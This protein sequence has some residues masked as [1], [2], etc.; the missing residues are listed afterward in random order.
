MRT[1]VAAAAIVLAAIASA[2]ESDIVTTKVIGKEFPGQYKHPASFAELDNGDLYLAYYG[3]GGEYEDDSKVWGM[4]LR[5]GTEQWSTPEIIAD[6]P[7]LGEG[8]P[9]VWQAPDATVWLFYVQRYGETWSESR[10]NAKI[11]RDGARIWS[12]SF[13][14]AFEKGMM[15]RGRPIL[16]QDGDYLLPIYHETGNDRE[17]VGADTTSLFIRIDPDTH[18]WKETGRITSRT[19]NLQPAPVEIE[20]GHLIAY[21]RRGGGYE[22]VTDGYVVR[23]ESR[24]GGWTWSPGVDSA[25]PNPNAAVDFIKLANGH[26]LL[27]YNDSML[28][29]DPLTVAIST[30]NDKTWTHR[31]NIAEGKEDF[32]YPV[33]LQAKDGKIHIIYT[34]DERATIMHAAFDETAILGSRKGRGR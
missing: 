29:R 4:R 1:S 22:P 2:A 13:V 3:G 14:L 17:N 28:D 19:G 31:K 18:T 16:L 8:N 24:D 21:C 20:P 12:D 30:D 6:T 5:A 26:L 7:F 27:V 25:F 15:V 23:S 11:S 9:V 34:K 32:A 33:A 10:I